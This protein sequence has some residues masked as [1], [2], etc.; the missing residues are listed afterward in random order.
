MRV[1]LL[2]SGQERY[3]DRLPA[4]IQEVQLSSDLLQ[5]GEAGQ[6]TED[7]QGAY[8]DE[9]V[10][11]DGVY[12]N[13]DENDFMENKYYYDYESDFGIL[14]EDHTTVQNKRCLTTLNPQ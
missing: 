12:Y 11:Y 5:Q 7:Q 3:Q 6:Q 10:Q 14:T 9:Q 1:F 4:Q 13:G 2:P 8:G